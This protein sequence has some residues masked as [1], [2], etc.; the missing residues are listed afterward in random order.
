MFD[1]IEHGGLPCVLPFAVH[2]D[3]VPLFL[4]IFIFQTPPHILDE[5]PEHVVLHWDLGRT[6]D[7]GGA[8]LPQK[9]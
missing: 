1:P 4:K 3:F 9:H 6:F 5:S 7:D 2:L 8:L